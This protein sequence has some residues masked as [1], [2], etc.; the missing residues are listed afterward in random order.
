MPGDQDACD[1]TKGLFCDPVGLHCT[2]TVYV[3][4]GGNCQDTPSMHFACTGGGECRGGGTCEA[5]V[6]D[7]QRGPCLSPATAVGMVCLLP[8]PAICE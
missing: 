4:P 1:R 7:G 2:A 3:A 8:D 5:P 6:G